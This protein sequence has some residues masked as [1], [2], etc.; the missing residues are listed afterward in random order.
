MRK[1]EL[2]IKGEILFYSSFIFVSAFLIFNA[3]VLTFTKFQLQKIEES[4]YAE[5]LQISI[6]SLERGKI[7]EIPSASLFLIDPQKEENEKLRDECINLTGIKKVFKDS[8]L[9][10]VVSFYDNGVKK[11]AVYNFKRG[12]YLSTLGS[13]ALNFLLFTFLFSAGFIIFAYSVL[14]RV[15]IKPLIELFNA[16]REISAG[17]EEKRASESGPKEIKYL[18][19]SFNRT[20][21]ELIM[22]KR[23]L[24]KIVKELEFVNKEMERTQEEI[25]QAERLASIGRLSAGVAHEL[26]NPLSTIIMLLELL[27]SHADE[28]GLGYVKKIEGELDRMN[29][30]IKNLLDLSRPFKAELKKFNP[31]EVIKNLLSIVFTERD[32]DYVKIEFLPGGVNEVLSDPNIF[33]QILI[34]ILLNAKD[35]VREKGKGEIIIRIE[36]EEEYFVTE[37]RDTGIGMDKEVLGRIFEPFFTTKPPDRGTGLGLSISRRLAE[38]LGGKIIAISEKGKGSSFKIYIPI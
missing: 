10:Y 2:G 17:N 36:K 5:L 22:K 35:A 13:L 1:F 33:S 15:V 8:F 16:V 14:T 26:G 38:I 29:R 3:I 24:E 9:K 19:S 32:K 25:I 34:N 28:K 4:H 23:E 6:K 37:V 7:L 21:E 27:K 31:E 30:I 20:F 12:R 11:C 18:S